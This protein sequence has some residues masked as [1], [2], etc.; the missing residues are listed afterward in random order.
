MTQPVTTFPLSMR[1]FHWGMA[2][3]VL[4]MIF[5]GLAMV[6]SLQTWQPTVL[7]LHKAFGVVALVAVLLRLINRLRSRVPELP[8]DLPSW[9]V[10]AAKASHVLLYAALFAMPIS[11]YLMQSAAGRAVDVFGIFTLPP[12]MSADLVWYGVFREMHSWVAYALIA[13]LVVHIAAALQHGLLR[14]DGVLKSMWKR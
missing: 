11:G 1:I 7:A 8:S 4:S 14:Q 3:L 13:L 2:A 6:Q 5:A 12:L 10:F 9:Q